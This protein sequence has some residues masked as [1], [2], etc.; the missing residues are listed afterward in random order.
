MVPVPYPCLHPLLSS[1]NQGGPDIRVVLTERELMP[2]VC[3]EILYDGTLL[4]Y[5]TDAIFP[6]VKQMTHS[7]VIHLFSGKIHDDLKCKCGNTLITGYIKDVFLS[8]AI[9]CNKC[10]ELTLTPKLPYGEIL[11]NGLG[12]FVLEDREYF[13][14][15]PLF[16]DLRKIMM[17]NTTL[18][19]DQKMFD[20]VRQPLESTTFQDIVK[21]TQDI[22]NVLTKNSLSKHMCS[23]RRSKRTSET[24]KAEYPLPWALDYV[25]AAENLSLKDVSEDKNFIAATQFIL[26]FFDVMSRWKHHPV[27]EEFGEVFSG[28]KAFH[29][30]VSQ[31]MAAT[32]MV[33]GGNRV[34]LAKAIGEGIRTPDM[35]VN[36]AEIGRFHIEVKAP[37]ALQWASNTPL[38]DNVIELILKKHLQ[39]GQINSNNRGILVIGCTRF[40][41]IGRIN[42]VFKNTIKAIGRSHRGVA[43]IYVLQNRDFKIIAKNG[44]EALPEMI[45]ISQV[46][47]A[48]EHYKGD[49]PFRRGPSARL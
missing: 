11:P 1:Q 17:G 4:T 23:V 6:I 22:Y 16:L 5:S 38:T 13:I 37:E 45:P 15:A 26:S 19:Q 24:P 12:L 46:F 48:N 10:N 36:F 14:N 28:R 47:L 43:G 7:P 29:H 3:N 27:F 39:K 33:Q 2:R 20:P 21:K 42:K 25:T 34:G 9:E 8:V 31:L 32:I 40:G 35:Y 30:N 44:I 41:S 49:N 18:R